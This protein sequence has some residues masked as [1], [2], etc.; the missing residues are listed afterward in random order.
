[1]LHNGVFSKNAFCLVPRRPPV[2][3]TGCCGTAGVVPINATHLL[4]VLR[5]PSL[6]DLKERFHRFA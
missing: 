4:V 2:W 6:L 5:T 3:R 1:M